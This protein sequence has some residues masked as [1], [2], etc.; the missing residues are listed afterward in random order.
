VCKWVSIGS[1]LNQIRLTIENFFI[2][3][4]SS[5]L[6]L[7]S[8]YSTISYYNLISLIWLKF[9]IF[10]FRNLS[11]KKS[12]QWV[13]YNIISNY[14]PPP[15]FNVIGL[16]P[17]DGNEITSHY[18]MLHNFQSETSWS[19]FHLKKGMYS[20]LLLKRNM[21]WSKIVQRLKNQ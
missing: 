11:Q 19:A 6:I 9:K 20:R 13:F 1:F 14:F 15:F 7:N 17:A 10:N 2:L 4:H 12:F 3:K 5:I 18:L 16:V 21:L 8:R